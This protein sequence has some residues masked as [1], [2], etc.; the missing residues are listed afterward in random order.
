MAAKEWD[1][2][3]PNH[4]DPNRPLSHGVPSHLY[5]DENPATTIKGTGFKDRKTAERTISLTSQP[6]VR[7]KQ[8]WTVRANRERAVHHP[9]QTSGMRDAIEVFDGWLGRYNPPSS[10]E[11]RA[12]EEDWRKH[13]RLC[14]SSANGH[15][16]GKKPSGG[17]LKRAREDVKDGRDC[18]RR[19]L[20]LAHRVS[21][22]EVERPSS[23]VEVRFPLVAFT[24][25]FGGPGM[26]GYGEHVIDDDETRVVIEGMDG[27]QELIPKPIL[28]LGIKPKIVMVYHYRAREM[29]RAQIECDDDDQSCTTLDSI[30]KNVTASTAG[31]SSNV[32]IGARV[33]NGNSEEASWTCA[34]C[35][36]VHTGASKQLFLACEL[37]GASLHHPC[38]MTTTTKPTTTSIAEKL[39]SSPSASTPS[40]LPIAQPVSASQPTR[41]EDRPPGLTAWGSLRAP[42][43]SDIRGP[44]KRRKALE[45]QPPLLDYVIVLDFEWT[46]DDKRRIEPIA[47]ITQFP[48]VAMK[49]VDRNDGLPSVES[50]T[51]FANRTPVPVPADL[52]APMPHDSG[53]V[54]DAYAVSVF[55]SF[56]RPT[57]NPTLTPF[58]ITLTAITQAQVDTAPSIQKTLELYTNWLASLD[59]ID[60]HNNRRGNW[61][62]A[63][64][65]DVDIM[66]TLRLELA[67]KSIDL[68]PCFDRW[69][70]LK[71]DS[72]FRRH[73]GRRPRGGLRA[74]V[75]SVGATWE[76]RAHNGLVDSINTA[77]IVRDM[78]RTGFRFV[79]STR[80]LDRDGLPFGG[81][82]HGRT[83]GK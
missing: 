21:R 50:S 43:N 25:L 70:N 40:K 76:G 37:C 23:C 59:L 54:Q 64:W 29:A 49:L 62:F 53:V 4:H 82:T 8:Y 60:K 55:D 65:G 32:T 75:E 6:A 31:R 28:S 27:L 24:A 2:H 79:R 78:A 72:V 30:W 9:H 58:S 38:T 80:G 83:L 22:K 67:Y 56:V 71:D 34:T 35:T 15:A 13:R 18:L 63:T 57:L 19:C 66:T 52:A 46:A 48:S 12:Q 1:H 42:S 7:F 44:R 81:Q 69:I 73:Y 33:T 51:S 45:L 77:K 74:C 68:P 5:T 41:L 26:H 17:Q 3:H 11:R 47:E 16:Y 36:Y 14:D 10:E 39:P 61:C 20:E